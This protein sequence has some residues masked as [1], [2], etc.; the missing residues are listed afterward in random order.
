M[1]TSA[2]GVVPTRPVDPGVVRG[3]FAERIAQSALWAKATTIA[4]IVEMG[5]TSGTMPIDGTYRG[6]NLQD[7][8]TVATAK[9]MAGDVYKDL[10]VTL[11]TEAYELERYTLGKYELS[12]LKANALNLDNGVDIEAHVAS[13]FAD[14]A[15][16]LH[17]YKV[18]TAITTAG[19]YASGYSADGGNITSADFDLIGLLDTA[20]NKLVDGQAWDGSSAID[21]FISRDVLPYLQKLT[22]VRNA[23][24]NANANY[25]TPGEI[26]TWFAAYLQGSRVHIDEGRYKAVNGTITKTSTGSIAFSVPRSGTFGRGNVVT[27]TGANLGAGILDL[28]MQENAAHAGGGQDIFADAFYRVHVEDING[29][30]STSGYLAHTLLS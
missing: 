8:A 23:A 1:T 7:D 3:L 2:Q 29:S 26:A 19:N 20:G 4:P 30:K 11:D 17:Y 18:A 22:Q 5:A 16:A 25:P 9:A 24:G 12:Y 6:V 13:V 14:K 15:A 28:R 27:L 21:V 10:L